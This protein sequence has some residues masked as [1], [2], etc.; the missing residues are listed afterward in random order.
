MT[1]P[2]HAHLPRKMI[3][4]PAPVSGTLRRV[5]FAR[6]RLPHLAVALLTA[7]FVGCATYEPKPLAPEQSAAAFEAR[8]LESPGLREFIEERLGRPL[9]LWP[10]KQQQTDFIS[11]N[12]AWNVELLTLTAYYFHPSLDVARARWR[13]AEAAEIS[14]GAR[15]N[16]T[17]SLQPG[18]NFS[19]APGVTPWIPGAQFDLP[20]ET[21]GKR[22]L[23][24][25]KARQATEVARL[26]LHTAAWK[27]RSEVRDALSRCAFAGEQVHMLEIKAGTQHRLTERL[28]QRLSAG[29]ATL[30]DVL[31]ARLALQKTKLETSLAWESSKVS[32]ARAAEAIGISTHEFESVLVAHRFSPGLIMSV[33]LPLCS[34][35]LGPNPQPEAVAKFAID[36]LPATSLEALAG[37]LQIVLPALTN[38]MAAE[39][40][41]SAAQARP[42]IRAALADYEAAQL[43]LRLEIARQYPDI[44]L[45][46][47]YQWDQGESKWSFLSLSAELPVLN[48]NQG[49]IAEAKARREE[50]AARVVTTQ[51]RVFAETD[52]AAPA[53]ERARSRFFSTLSYFETQ[54]HLVE[55]VIAQVKAGAA[56]E[57][58]QLTA[59]LEQT[60]AFLMI[61]EARHQAETALGKLEDALQMP[62]DRSR[63]APL[64]GEFIQA[65]PRVGK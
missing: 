10:L 19:A 39:L 38:A 50:A 1:P 60:N 34:Q 55:S 30:A 25:A 35:T 40:R 17:V 23:R 64:P 36:R 11:L 48:R 63:S 46:S 13:A 56:D 7:V 33:V 52:A 57:F 21:A 20:I 2:T 41:A 37:R 53:Y 62:L 24:A 65:N 45:G 58:D 59:L 4:Q 49:A 44:H 26:E 3:C 43:A 22:G 8:S 29:A 5:N 28:Q 54:S 27:V 32:S 18:Y 6:A 12:Q 16:P 31:P 47:G 61:I 14:A 42:E 15:P 9:P 51:V